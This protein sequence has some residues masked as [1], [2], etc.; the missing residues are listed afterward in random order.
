MATRGESKTL[1]VFCIATAD[2]KLEELR[3]V[4]D[5][6]RS[7]LNFFARGSPHK[8]RVLELLFSVLCIVKIFV[9]FSYALF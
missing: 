9:K 4:S 2:T 3:F 5:A 8:V 6:V 7:N 1:R